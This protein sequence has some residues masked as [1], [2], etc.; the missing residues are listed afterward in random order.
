MLKE[1]GCLA[2]NFWRAPTDN[3]FGANLHKKWNAWKNPGLKLLQLKTGMEN[4]QAVVRAEYE[5]SCR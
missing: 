4:N 1:G 3:D 5:M 2:P